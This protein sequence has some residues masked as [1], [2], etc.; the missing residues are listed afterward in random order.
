MYVFRYLVETLYNDHIRIHD[1]PN[2]FSFAL[3]GNPENIKT[4]LNFLRNQYANIREQ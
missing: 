1:K 2:A 4:A 3:Q